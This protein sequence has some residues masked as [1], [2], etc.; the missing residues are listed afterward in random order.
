[1]GLDGPVGGLT[2]DRDRGTLLVIDQP[3]ATVVEIRLSG[4]GI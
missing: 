4:L 1:M 3:T 2:I